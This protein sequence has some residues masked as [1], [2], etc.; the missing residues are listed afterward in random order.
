M[1]TVPFNIPPRSSIAIQ[2]GLDDYSLEAGITYLT[3]EPLR[4]V[5]SVPGLALVALAASAVLYL[6]GLAWLGA[7]IGFE[8]A[9][10]VG[11]MLATFASR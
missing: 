1:S 5:R 4:G 11:M 10:A 9:I 6:P 7:A 3:N 2:T 8:K